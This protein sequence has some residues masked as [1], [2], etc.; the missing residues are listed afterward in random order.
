M[1]GVKEE[2]NPLVI[3]ATANGFTSGDVYFNTANPGE[4]GWLSANGTVS[5]LTWC[6][7][8]NEAGLR[9][10]KFRFLLLEQPQSDSCQFVPKQSA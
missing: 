2:R 1:H 9:V 10:I 6:V 8:T 4:I 7:L 5:N 3:Q